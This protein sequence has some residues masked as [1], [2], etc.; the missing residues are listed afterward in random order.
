MLGTSNTKVS[1]ILPLP[2]LERKIVIKEVNK[3]WSS[4]LLIVVDAVKS[5]NE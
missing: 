5:V 1:Q 4:Q 2:I 3:Q